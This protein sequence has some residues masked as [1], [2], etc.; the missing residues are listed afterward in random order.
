MT[1]RR[2]TDVTWLLGHHTERCAAPCP[3][4][5]KRCWTS[6]A[7]PNTSWTPVRLV[8]HE[9]ISELFHFRDRGGRDRHD[10]RA[11][12]AQQAG[13]PQRQPWRQGDAVF[14]R[15]RRR[16]RPHRAKRHG[17]H[18]LPHG[19]GAA[20][21][22]GRHPQRLPAV[23]Q[24]DRRGYPQDHLQRRRRHQD[25]VSALFPADAAQGHGAVQRDVIALRDPADGR[26][27]MVLLLRA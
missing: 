10:Q 5:R 11:R 18:A 27:R 16:V 4:T 17:R 22:A 7:P 21:G 25:R 15:H 6:R 24:Q 23:L 8:A 13:L 26:G 14:P 3:V 12:H 20:I 19:P 2:R 1:F 9:T